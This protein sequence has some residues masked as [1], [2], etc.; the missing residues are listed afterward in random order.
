MSGPSSGG[1]FWDSSAVFLVVGL[2]VGVMVVG[3]AIVAGLP[4]DPETPSRVLAPVTPTETGPES[5]TTTPAGAEPKPARFT[6]TIT[7]AG[8]GRGTIGVDGE[9]RD[10]SDE[11][12]FALEAGVQVT[13][14]ARERAGSRFAGWT[15]PCDVE[16]TCRL[17]MNAARSVIAL[18]DLA[19]PSLTDCED[20]IDND[21]DELI[22]AEDPEC[23]DSDSE[24]Q[25]VVRPPPQAPLP[26]VITP[27]PPPAR[28]PPPPP[29]P[30]AVP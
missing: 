2:L 16:R 24:D 12:R 20:G 15:A 3:G 14:V 5:Q 29:P 21:I 25:P 18:F 9:T 26:P 30:V 13:L 11:C 28:P 22:D 7:N 19:G 10:C 27:P 4:G 1:S 17:S 6:L 23:A 8:D